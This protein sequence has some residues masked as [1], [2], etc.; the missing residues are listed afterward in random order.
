VSRPA[1]T[2]LAQLD[3]IRGLSVLAVVC[4]HWIPAANAFGH[5][6]LLGVYVFFVL[7]GFLITRILL[8]AVRARDEG[9]TTTGQV[10]RGFFGRRVL[11]IFPPYYFAVVASYLLWP[12]RFGDDLPWNL[13][14]LANMRAF[15][16]GR[17]LA[18]NPLWSLAVE[19]QFYLVWPFLVLLVPRRRLPAVLAALVAIAPIW[20]VLA[21]TSGLRHVVHTYPVWSNLDCL[22][23]GALL[24][25]SFEHSLRPR[26][27]R[28]AGGLGVA[29]FVL[30]GALTHSYGGWKAAGRTDAYAVVFVLYPLSVSLL[31]VWLVA[32]GAGEP[33]GALGRVLM[34]RPVRFVGLISYGVYVYHFFMQG[35]FDYAASEWFA[36]H[37]SPVGVFAGR[38][39]ATLA[40]AMLSWWV[41]ERPAI[42]LKRY[43]PYERA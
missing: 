24:A 5:V 34:L 28:V 21:V 20:R 35:I 27:T 36:L 38:L 30:C 15:M 19:E 31:G 43:F 23:L 2:H 11:R 26:W 12:R 33:V 6:G 17:S 25:V 39:V 37:L 18:I 29:L 4:S 10:L 9:A 13:T 42:A 32:R 41:L 40:F 16:L 14:Y 7:S 3:G 22:G 1:T 8:D